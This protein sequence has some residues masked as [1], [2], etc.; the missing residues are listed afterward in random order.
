M[1][2]GSACNLQ[3]RSVIPAPLEPSR[4]ITVN[5]L[6]VIDVKLKF[7]QAR[8]RRVDFCQDFQGETEIIKEVTGN[9]DGIDRFNQQLDVVV[10]ARLCSVTQI[11]H[12][13]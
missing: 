5:F 9:I 11:A 13:D 6:T 2:I 7:E 1:A 4:D 10:R 3:V 12:I 8:G